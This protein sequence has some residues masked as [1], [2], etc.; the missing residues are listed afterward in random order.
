MQTNGKNKTIKM[1]TVIQIILLAA[2]IVLGYFLYQSI[3][4]PISFNKERKQR[5]NKTIERLKD[6]RTAQLAYKSTNDEFTG[7]FDTLINF[8]KTDSMPIVR[9]IGHVPDTMTE[10]K[11]VELGLVTRDT[12]KVSTLD[13]LFSTQYPIDSLRYIPASG[14][15]EFILGAK[16]LETKSGVNVPVFEARAPNHLILKG[17]PEQQIVNLNAEAE[18]LERYPGLKVGSLRETNN[19]AGN[20]E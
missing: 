2:I 5:Y 12:S 10:K 14:G 19:N 11:A 15:E 7:S 8:I 6:I 9:A 1:R 3:E 4:E 13:S 18:R 16:I 20:W 17:L